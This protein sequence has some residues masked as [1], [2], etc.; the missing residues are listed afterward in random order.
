MGPFDTAQLK[1]AF[2]RHVLEHIANADDAVHA[3]EQMLMGLI[4]AQQD[5]RDAGF[6]NDDGSLSWRYHEATHRALDRLPSELELE[7]KLGL[8]SRFLDMCLVDGHLDRAE[9]SALFEAARL[10][11]VTSSQFDAHLSTLHDVGEV[12]LGESLDESPVAEE[13]R[14]QSGHIDLQGE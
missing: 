3:D 13:W 11:G 9:G 5:M 12:E 2:T 1:I 6:L 4:V 10:L 7:E 14:P 8:V